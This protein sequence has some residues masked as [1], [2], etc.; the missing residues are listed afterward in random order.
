M[1]LKTSALVWVDIAILYCE[2]KLNKDQKK[3]S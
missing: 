3:S 2:N 1:T